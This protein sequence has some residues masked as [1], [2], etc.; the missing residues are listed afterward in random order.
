M[1]KA[2]PED[3]QLT[4]VHDA[5]HW[6]DPMPPLAF[7]IAGQALAQGLLSAARSYDLPVGD[8]RVRRIDTYRYQATVPLVSASQEE[9]DARKKRSRDK[10]RAAITGLGN[11]WTH[12]WLPEI[13]RHLAYWEDFDLHAAHTSALLAHLDE[14]LV[15]ATRMWEIHFVLHYP[16]HRAIKQFTSLYQELFGGAELDAYKLL[17]GFDNRTLQMGR[18][19]W[20]LSRQALG[21][22]PV[23]EAIQR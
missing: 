5:V 4:W 21:S 19:L 22:R 2:E 13:E 12:E 14:T 17:Q 15:R 11:L 10:L 3:E 8:V 9:T 6:P 23:V 16:M 20:E 18:A 7:A 1:N